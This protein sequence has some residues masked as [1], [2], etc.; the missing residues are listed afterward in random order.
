MFT[1]LTPHTVNIHTGGVVLTLPP[2]GKS[3]RVA[4][5]PVAVGEHDG[6]TIFDVEYGELEMVDNATKEVTTGLP[7]VVD[8][9]LYI[10]A[11]QCTDKIRAVG[12]KDFVS[13]GD[14]IRDDKG[15]PCGCK[16]VKRI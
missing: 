14:L 2:T 13:P 9:T 4:A 7:P 16:G 12:R 10:V 11:G 8:G 15:Q 6:V 3:L 1:N 5:N